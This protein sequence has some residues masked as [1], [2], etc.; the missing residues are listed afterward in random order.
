MILITVLEI[1]YAFGVVF[2]A[3]D[4]CQRV[5]LEFDECNQMIG[6][7]EWYLFPAEIQRILPIIMNYTQQPVDIRCF[8]TAACDRETF[9]Y[10]RILSV[11]FFFHRQL[12]HLKYIFMSF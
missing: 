12:M 6:Q 7:F 11:I 5:N 10:V 8:G 3:S 4:L 1:I 2:I 9:K